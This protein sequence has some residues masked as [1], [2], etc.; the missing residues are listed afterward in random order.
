MDAKP[1]PLTFRPY[2]DAAL[3][4]V[5][6]DFVGSL[7]KARTASIR[8]KDYNSPDADR[9]KLDD[10]DSKIRSALKKCYKF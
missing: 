1:T 10:A 7:L 3:A 4:P 6:A 9:L 8:I 5:E 2:E